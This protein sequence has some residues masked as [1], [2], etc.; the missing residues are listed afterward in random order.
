MITDH[1]FACPQLRFLRIFA[2]S[3]SVQLRFYTFD[4]EDEMPTFLKSMLGAFHISELFYVFGGSSPGGNL[5]LGGGALGFGLSWGE[6]E[7][8]LAARTSSNW[9]AL[10]RSDAIALQ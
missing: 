9:T 4:A 6:N 7:K 2:T 3:R 1:L 8:A 5:P 10:G